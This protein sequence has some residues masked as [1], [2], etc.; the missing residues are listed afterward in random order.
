MVRTIIQLEEAQ[1]RKLKSLAS[2]RSQ[3]IAQLVREAVDAMLTQAAG[4]QQWT[5][6]RQAAGTCHDRDAAT[7]VAE[8]HDA[9]LV[10]AYRS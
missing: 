9:Y 5:R 4:D 2:A 1:V 6:L 3:S 7:D 8:R 10:D